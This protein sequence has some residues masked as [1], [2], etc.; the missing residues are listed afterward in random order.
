MDGHFK[1]LY[2]HPTMTITWLDEKPAANVIEAYTDWLI[3]EERVLRTSSDEKE[4]FRAQ[5]RVEIL[6]RFI[7]L[8]KELIDLKKGGGK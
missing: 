4:I 8:R 7:G 6:R 2:E 3:A 5:G 1:K